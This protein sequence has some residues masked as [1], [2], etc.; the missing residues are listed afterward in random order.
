M[1]N[2]TKKQGVGESAKPLDTGKNVTC[3]QMTKHQLPTEAQHFADF[4]SFILHHV[5]IF[6]S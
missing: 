5:P 3:G 6:W 4:G 2:M 1:T